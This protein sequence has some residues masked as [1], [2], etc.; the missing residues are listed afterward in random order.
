[1]IN[2]KCALFSLEITLQ[3][4]L[5]HLRL[6]ALHSSQNTVTSTM[7]TTQT[8]DVQHRIYLVRAN[9]FERNGCQNM[10]RN[11]FIYSNQFPLFMKN[12]IFSMT[13][14]VSSYFHI[15]TEKRGI[16]AFAVGGILENKCYLKNSGVNWC[17]N[18]KTKQQIGV[19]LYIL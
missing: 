8:G 7:K 3:C 18:S 10:I 19:A 14:G 12:P 1:M 17:R 13:K 9:S 6:S 4:T 2:F 15:S 5:V 16:F 11:K